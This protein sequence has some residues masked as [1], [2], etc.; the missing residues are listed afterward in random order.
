MR[1]VLC[2]RIVLGLAVLTISVVCATSLM[3]QPPGK[4][5]KRPKGPPRDAEFL[6]VTGTVKDFTTAPKG[7]ADGLILDDGTWVH[8]PPHL[9][10]RFGDMAQKGDKVRVSGYMETAE[11]DTK[12]EVS[13]LTNL[14]TRKAIDNPDRPPPPDGADQPGRAPVPRAGPAMSRNACKHW[15]TSSTSR[16]R[17]CSGCGARSKRGLPAQDESGVLWPWPGAGKRRPDAIT[18]RVLKGQMMAVAVTRIGTAGNG[19]PT[20]ADAGH[21]VSLQSRV[22]LNAANFFLAEI[23]GV[24]MPFLGA[25]LQQ[26]Q[27]RYDA[28]GVAAA[29]AGLGVF[30]MQTPAGFIVDRVARRR[31]CWR[32]HRC[33]WVSAMGWCPSAGPPVC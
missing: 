10:D 7:E 32:G 30:L 13:T 3:A 16:A 14:R 27:W 4:K 25:F 17:K 20:Q 22:G 11:G 5:G 28:I 6:T 23:T 31:A 26:N 19:K 21:A 9:G 1:K 2:N 12:L 15:K 18:R 29:L 33:C 24:V 8:W